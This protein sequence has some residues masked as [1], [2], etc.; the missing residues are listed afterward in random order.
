[1]RT[2]VPPYLAVGAK[3]VVLTEDG[4]YLERAKG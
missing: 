3:I 1:V 2:T 4:S